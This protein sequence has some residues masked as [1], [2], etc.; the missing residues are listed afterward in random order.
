LLGGF[1]E[2]Q[3]DLREAVPEGAVVV[4]PREADVLVGEVAEPLERGIDLEASA[5]NQSE[6][7]PQP[8]FVDYL[9]PS[10]KA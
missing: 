6:E 3:D 7:L 10:D 1:S 8:F 5:L 4:D 2:A 9:P